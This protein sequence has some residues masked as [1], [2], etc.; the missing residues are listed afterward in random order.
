MNHQL[1]KFG[2]FIALLITVGYLLAACEPVALD[3]QNGANLGTKP[4]P[5]SGG[6]DSGKPFQTQATLRQNLCGVGLWGGLV[7]ELPDGTIVQP[8]SAADQ[9]VADFPAV[10]NR[11]VSV[12]FEEVP[13]DNRYDTIPRCMAYSPLEA[14]IAKVVKINRIK[15]ENGGGDN[16][17]PLEATVTVRQN[18]C[19]LGIWG[20]LVLELDNGD[21]LQPWELAPSA[22]GLAKINLENGQKV[23]I[24]YH[25]MARDNRYD[26]AVTC[27]AIG[28]YSDRIKGAIKIYALRAD[29]QPEPPT[30]RKYT[31]TAEVVDWGCAAFG[32]WQGIQFKT[33]SG[34]YL[35]PWELLPR[36]DPSAFAL[37]AGQ[38]VALTYAAKTPDDRYKE[39]Q[40]CPTF[41]PLPA[42][43][44][45]QVVGLRILP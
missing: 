2:A 5:G 29:D 8:W 26:S 42:A 17:L 10:A 43:Q 38:K 32:V 28:A 31:V 37:K 27:A 22:A 45:I 40:V 33:D 21:V 39:V 6:I 23:R 16:K 18:T 1:K 19:G 14:Q 11:V 13:R 4:G 44:P 24:K 30:S 7:L 9:Q 34:A 20:S 15:A 35:Q 12:D 3:P 25:V 41:A 36:I